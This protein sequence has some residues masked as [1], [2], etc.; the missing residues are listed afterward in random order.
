MRPFVLAAS[1]LALSL[2]LP[3]TTAKSLWSNTP[4]DNDNFIT[5]AIP[6]GNGRLGAMPLGAY[7]KEIIN[8]NIDSLWRGGPFEDE[9]YTGG[10]PNASIAAALPDIRDFIFQNKTGN[11]SALLGEFPHYGSYQVLGNLTVDLGPLDHVHG[12]RRTLDLESGVYTDGFSFEK[13]GRNA[14]VQREAFCSYPDQVCV[15]RVRSESGLP[16]VQIGLENR[17]VEP[18]PKVSCQGNSLV[19]HGQTAPSIGM[20]YNARATVVTGSKT[21]KDLC[22]LSSSTST[23]KIPP[24]QPEVYIILAAGTN[25]DSSKGNAADGY[26]F[27]GEDPTSRV[28]ETVTKAIRKKSFTRLKKSHIADF[29]SIYGDFTLSLPDPNGSAKK[30]TTD[31]LASYDQPGDPFVENLLFDYGRYLFLSASRPGSLPPNLQGLWTEQDSPAWKA[32]YHANINLQMNHWGVETTGLGGQTE[33]LWTYMTETWMPRGAETARLLYGAEEGWVV[34]NEVNIFGHTAMKNGA[35]WANYPV[36]NAWMAQHVWDHFDYTQNVTWYRQTGYPILK[37]TAH[38]WLSQL[39]EDEYSQDGTLVVNPC[40]SPEHG[41]TTFGCTHYQQLIWEVFDHILQG[42]SAS[43]DTNGTFKAAISAAHTKLDP[44]IHIGSWGQI[45]E[46]KL[47]IDTPND[48]HRHL[49]ELY[50]WYPGY[51]LSSVHGSNRTISSAVAKTLTSRGDGTHDQN[52]GWGKV[53]RSACWAVLRDAEKAYELLTLA[54]RDNIAPNGLSMYGGSPPFQIDANYGILGAVVAMLI[55]DLDGR[56]AGAAR[57]QE[58]VLGPAIPAAW[59]GGSVKGLRLRGGGRVGFSWDEKGVV[60]SCRADL[61]GS[62]KGV[63]ELVFSVRGGKSI[64]C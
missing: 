19:L 1:T 31:L 3:L 24:G 45:Q 2:S 25:Y 62:G 47:D 28:Q 44:G 17:V 49:S 46:W 55:R 60:T 16:A 4:G 23:V 35:E 39:V 54:V 64:A 63:P 51:L 7:G 36:V 26:S 33:P 30:P 40:N 57:V 9:S 14:S 5:T 18:A 12:Y 34:H 10:N 20:I 43:D 15:Y 32:D 37:G 42:W 41:P 6:L 13:G 27:K 50:G 59:G 22:S 58:V 52:T 61:K 48:T 56:R 8:L 11:V 29:Q 38:F 53:W 21:S